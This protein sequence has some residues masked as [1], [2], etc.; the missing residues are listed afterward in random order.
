MNGLNINV[1][2]VLHAINQLKIETRAY[3]ECL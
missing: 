1:N 3:I 2:Q